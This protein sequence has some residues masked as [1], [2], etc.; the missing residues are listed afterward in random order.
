MHIII[1][2]LN[3]KQVSFVSLSPDIQD[4]FPGG[5]TVMVSGFPARG[6]LGIKGVHTCCSVPSVSI[7]APRL[8]LAQEYILE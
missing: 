3:E 1:Q 7:C 8:L 4:L 6:V 5:N 2:S